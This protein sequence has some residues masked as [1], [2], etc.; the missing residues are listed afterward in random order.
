M[1]QQILT[2]NFLAFGTVV[3]LG[4]LIGLERSVAASDNP[5]STIRD[6]VIVALLGGIS[7]YAAIQYDNSW[8][9]LGG[10]IGVVTLILL[11]Y[12]VE[13]RR[14]KDADPGI[15]TEAAALATF[16]LSR[17]RLNWRWLWPSSC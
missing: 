5:H 2:A 14:H 11:E 3:L 10:L 1:E 16:L 4:F 6:F 7:A 13:H 17:A 8:L 9:I 12:T 15:T